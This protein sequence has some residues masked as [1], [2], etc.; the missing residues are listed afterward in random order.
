MI[1]VILFDDFTDTFSLAI[2]S[3]KIYL[4]KNIQEYFTFKNNSKIYYR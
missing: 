1:N 4:F 2:S 3:L